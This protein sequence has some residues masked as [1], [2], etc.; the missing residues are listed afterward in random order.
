MV[1]SAYRVSN[2]PKTY[3]QAMVAARAQAGRLS[4]QGTLNVSRA[5]DEY[6]N[7]LSKKLRSLRLTNASDARW[8]AALKATIKVNRDAARHLRNSL[9]SSVGDLRGLS[10]SE[11]QAIW[12]DASLAAAKAIGV[13]AATMG[14]VSAPPITL[15]GMYENLG[16][17]GT[18]KTLLP[19]Y[20]QAGAVDVEGII[21]AAFTEQ[22]SPSALARSLRPYVLGK[23][24]FME[25][26]GDLP[27]IDPK[28]LRKLSLQQFKNPKALEALQSDA[29]SK[30]KFNADR[31]AFSETYN[32]RAEAEV[33]HFAVDPIVAAIKWSLAVDRGTQISPDECDIYAKTNFYGLGPG[34]YPVSKVPLVPHPF[35]RC[36]RS[37]VQRPFSEVGKP[38]PNPARRID[39]RTVRVPRQLSKDGHKLTNNEVIRVRQRVAAN[40]AAVN[41]SPAQ[42][43]IQELSEAST[44]V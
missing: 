4:L 13:P 39:P 17:A 14:I 8:A 6:A 9:V 21:R 40:F 11:T 23:E 28:D 43:S 32:A 24:D 36:E 16:G 10:F 42:R 44:D 20:A 19:Q 34:V 22:I 35:D 30:M 7:T 37:P 29:A 15:L 2:G 12:L 3:R 33:Q 26:F 1:D 5:L 25:A 38:K 41:D 18:F 31:I 27:G